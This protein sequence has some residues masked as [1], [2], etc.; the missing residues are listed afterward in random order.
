MMVFKHDHTDIGY[1]RVCFTVQGAKNPKNTYY[2]C[3][4]E[5]IEGVVLMYR[6]GDG[7]WWEPDYSVVIT[8]EYSFDLPNDIDDYAKNLIE[9]WK[10][11][12][13]EKTDDK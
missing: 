3:I 5:E 4:Q 10:K 2:Y 7:D 12:N 6:C 9:Q 11:T 1:A 13:K 8:G